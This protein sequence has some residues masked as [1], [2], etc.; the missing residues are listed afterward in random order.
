MSSNPCIF[1]I[2]YSASYHLQIF[3]PLEIPDKE[4]FRCMV[5]GH[6]DFALTGL[7]GGGGEER[8]GAATS[9]LCNSMLVF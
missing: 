3:I 4:Y 5:H 6:A 1:S 9:K 8:E 7:G 2:K